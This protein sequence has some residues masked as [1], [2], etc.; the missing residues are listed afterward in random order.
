MP[1]LKP[2]H[3]QPVT[4]SL[5]HLRTLQQIRSPLRQLSTKLITSSRLCLDTILQRQCF[6]R[7]RVAK[8]IG[9]PWRTSCNSV[10]EQMQNPVQQPKELVAIVDVDNN[11]IDRVARK[12]MREKNLRHRC[13]FIVVYNSKDVLPLVKT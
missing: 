1:S 13:T 7:E 2:K 6:H 8:R 10:S 9:T 12:E 11:V 4:S 3:M 5:L